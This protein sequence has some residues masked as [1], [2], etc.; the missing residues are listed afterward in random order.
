[1]AVI[2]SA[3]PVGL[4]FIDAGATSVWVESV[5]RFGCLQTLRGWARDL[6]KRIS[7]PQSCKEDHF[8]ALALY[9]AAW[10]KVYE[11]RSPLWPP[12]LQNIGGFHSKKMFSGLNAGLLGHA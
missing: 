9:S 5:P 11:Y 2:I 10:R 4:E 8:D 6:R 1:M 3:K 7:S 12:S